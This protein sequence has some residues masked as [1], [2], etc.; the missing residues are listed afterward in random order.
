MKTTHLAAVATLVYLLSSSLIADTDEEHYFH[1]ASECARGAQVTEEIKLNSGVYNEQV[2]VST[3]LKINISREMNEQAYLECMN[4]TG[5]L[6]DADRDPYLQ[7]IRECNQ[8]VTTERTV[9]GQ[10]EVRIGS[11]RNQK[12][13][14][15]CLR[16]VEVELLPAE[17]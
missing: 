2:Q 10:G 14:E 5:L 16:G 13:Y 3:P 1:A 17:E 15:D 4:K 11:T 9:I 7:R 6:P 12:A 8:G